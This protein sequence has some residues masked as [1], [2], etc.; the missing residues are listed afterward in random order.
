MP[1]I[2]L[3]TRDFTSPLSL[4][5]TWAL[6]SGCLTFSLVASL[7]TPERAASLDPSD[8]A[9]LSTF[10]I[11]CM[12]TWCLFFVLTLLI[13]VLSVIQFHSL[14]PVSWKNLTVTVASLASL[15][16][17]SASVIFPGMIVD[18]NVAGP[19]HVVATVASC[20][21]FLAYASEAFLI[22]TQ[23]REQRGYMASAPGLLKVLQFWGGCQ[24]IPLFVEGSRRALQAGDGEDMAWP[25]SW[26]QLWVSGVAYAICLVMSLGTVVVVL[27]DWAG[28][29]PVPFDRLLTGFSLTGVLLYVVATI[30]C[31]TRVLRLPTLCKK[32]IRFCPV[33]VVMETVVAS[34]TLLAYTVD[35]AFSIK[36]LRDRS[37]P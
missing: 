16:V 28:R 35:L 4:V 1:V 33:Q 18:H 27:G 6:L 25:W 5:R 36:L 24:M 9:P 8:R 26:W 13:H 21:T 23:S 22:R 37:H 12:F 29:C 20:L 34:V 15:M 31:F 32:N 19:R 11:L 2:V 14:I 3:E 17:L 7:H 10:W 30:L